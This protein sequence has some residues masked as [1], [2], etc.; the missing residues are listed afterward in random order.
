M[1][2]DTRLYR[3]VNREMWESFC[4]RFKSPT[5]RASYES[6]LAQFCELVNKPFHEAD[7]A[8]V[9]RYYRYMQACVR[10]KSIREITVTKK[11][12]ELHS[13]ASFCKEGEKEELFAPYL[14]RLPAEKPFVEA[15]TPKEMDLLLME[16]ADDPMVYLILTLMYR[17]GL[18]SAEMIALHG[19]DA[20]VETKEGVFLMP[21]GRRQPCFVP[22]DVWNQVKEYDRKVS[23]ANALVYADTRREDRLFLNRRGRP[24]NLMYISRM[25]EKYEKRAGISR[26]SARQIAAAC[27]ANLFAYGAKKK[28]VAR[29]KG[30]TQMQIGRYRLPGYEA[31]LKKAANEA[32]RI[33]IVPPAPKG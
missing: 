19:I 18:S 4:R 10:D 29:Q 15:I 27:Y 13:F 17:V 20:F 23:A 8:D 28:E 26:Y 16:A 25:L 22:D 2:N 14:L 21:K 5:T 3:F 31:K 12:R 30:R 11:F 6:D 9:E 33:R 24:L 32:V 1:P 7:G